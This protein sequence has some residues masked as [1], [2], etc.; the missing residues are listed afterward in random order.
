MRSRARRR[1]RGPLSHLN[2]NLLGPR[3]VMDGQVSSALVFWLL[4][5]CEDYSMAAGPAG[6]SSATPRATRL[7]N[8]GASSTRIKQCRDQENKI[9]TTDS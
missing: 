4:V 2:V 9:Q 3:F 8:P 1:R 5:L 7:L 6:A